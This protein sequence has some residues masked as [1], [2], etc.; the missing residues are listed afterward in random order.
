MPKAF[1]ALLLSLM[2]SRESE[3]SWGTS[4]LQ[5]DVIVLRPP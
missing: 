1:I 5:R 3:K 4:I 2:L